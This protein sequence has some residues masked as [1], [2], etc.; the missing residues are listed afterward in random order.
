MSIKKSRILL[1]GM[2]ISAAVLGCGSRSGS[3]EEDGRDPA[4]TAIY[5]MQ[6][7]EQDPLVEKEAEP[8][9][10]SAS[11]CINWLIDHA[12]VDEN[13]CYV[14]QET[15]DRSSDVGGG[16]KGSAVTRR[17]LSVKLS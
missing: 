5:A 14:W 16:I 17:R 8:D 6:Y 9:D 1:A 3:E 7:C 10:E 12:S 4:E 13:G 2:L 15:Y 11:E